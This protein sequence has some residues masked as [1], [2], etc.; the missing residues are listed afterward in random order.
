MR[1]LAFAPARSATPTRRLAS[2]VLTS[3]ALLAAATPRAVHATHY[4]V[5]AGGGGVTTIQAAVNQRRVQFRD[6]IL[7]WPGAYAETITLPT[8]ALQA[9]LI[10]TGGAAVTSAQ[11]IVITAP[12]WGRPANEQNRVEGFTFTAPVTFVSNFKRSYFYRCVFLAEVNANGGSGGVGNFEDCDF[13]ARTRFSAYLGYI[14]GPAYVPGPFQKLRFHSAPLTVL[15]D[16]SGPTGFRDCTFEGPADTL[17]TSFPSSD[18]VSLQS[19]TFAN[20]AYGDAIM[21]PSMSDQKIWNCRFTDL[22]AYGV[23]MEAGSTGYQQ[24]LLLYDSRFERCGVALRW[25]VN[26]SFGSYGPVML[27]D[28][29]LAATGNGVEIGRFRGIVSNSIVDGSGGHGVV[30]L[31]T[32][33]G[34][35]DS[36]PDATVTGST[37]SNNAGDGVRVEN[38]STYWPLPIYGQPNVVTNSAFVHNGGAGL[39]MTAA[40]WNV[41]DCVAYDNGAAGFACATTVTGGGSRLVGN[42]SVANGGDGFRVDAPAAGEDSLQLVQHDL[43]AFNDGAGFRVPAA[44]FGSLAFNDAWTN[45]LGAY[46]N[47]VSPADSN[48]TLDPRFC[49]LAAGVAGLGLEQGSPCAS[50]GVYNQIGAR[51]VECPATTGVTPTAPALAFAV[52]PSVARGSVEF[53]APAGGEGRVAVYDLAGRVVWRAALGGARASV[54]WQGE[55]ERGRARAGLYWVR[56]TRGAESAAQRLVWLE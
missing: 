37:F 15:N 14:N 20:A 49:N 8:V 26:S 36:P 55:G 16:G 56:F 48:L 5:D 7:V 9:Y 38:L 52:R 42:T 45:A 44:A 2:L 24:G 32:M 43:A 10:G 23:H 35:G 50:T 3:L 6:T 1:L 54:R 53:V 18:D 13:H 33:T 30:F 25:V 22:T 40:L 47:A 27:R 41:S 12:A 17:L 46:V 39:R 29:V 21:N 51:G 28:T 34:P 4:V 11:S 31:H 19:C